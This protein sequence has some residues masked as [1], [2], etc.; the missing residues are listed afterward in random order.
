MP[1]ET[2]RFEDL[3]ARFN[4]TKSMTQGTAMLHLLLQ[5]SNT[6]GSAGAVRGASAQHQGGVLESVFATKLAKQTTYKAA[7]K[8]SLSK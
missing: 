1:Q 5:L 8:G 7:D 6:E 4:R 2:Q 3:M